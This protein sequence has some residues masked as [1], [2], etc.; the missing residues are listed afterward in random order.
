[1]K[2]IITAILFA[3]CLISSGCQTAGEVPLNQELIKSYSGNP[4]EV[5]LPPEAQD[6]IIPVGNPFLYSNAV[7]GMR[8]EADELMAYGDF[9][10]AESVSGNYCITGWGN[11]LY[12][13]PVD[14]TVNENEYTVLCFKPGCTHP[15]NSSCPAYTGNYIAS[16]DSTVLDFHEGGKAPVLYYT[17]Y[18][19]KTRCT[20]VR[21]YNLW[22]GEQSTVLDDFKNTVSSILTYGDW[23]YLKTDQNKLYRLSKSCGELIELTEFSPDADQPYAN[24]FDLLGVTNDR[25]YI[26]ADIFK[27]YSVALDFSD[28]RLEFDM[29]GRNPDYGAKQ[30]ANPYFYIKNGYLYYMDDMEAVSLENLEL[31]FI[32]YEIKCNLYRLP[33]DRLSEEP[34]LIL[35]GIAHGG[36]YHRYAENYLYYEPLDFK[37]SNIAFDYRDISNGELRILDLNTLDDKSILRDTNLTICITDSYGTSIHFSGY[38][39]EKKGSLGSYTFSYSSGHLQF[40]L[41]ANGTC[42]RFR[43]YRYTRLSHGVLEAIYTE[44]QVFRFELQ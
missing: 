35:E 31:N 20:S 6:K 4:S 25:L 5:L 16:I 42:V 15:D 14:E 13:Y 17:T 23:L 26:W 39:T 32:I 8:T 36:S 7:E 38:M 34:E 3:A 21:R 24:D 11:K 41:K 18:N 9:W 29:T 12:Y 19:F 43:E 27:L 2:K 22:N 28:M 33:I 37:Y 40:A 30:D 44:R 1:M 10:N